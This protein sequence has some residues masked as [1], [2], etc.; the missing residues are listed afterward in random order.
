MKK[1]EII[2]DETENEVVLGLKTILSEKKSNGECDCQCH[3]IPGMKHIVACCFECPKCKKNIRF[4]EGEKYIN[5]E[6]RKIFKDRHIKN[7]EQN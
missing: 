2:L 3:V 1:P 6:D 5:G 7:C 4:K